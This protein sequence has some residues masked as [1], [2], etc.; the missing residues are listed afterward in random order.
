MT[1]S[2]KIGTPSLAWLTDFEEL[3]GSPAELVLQVQPNDPAF[4][5]FDFGP[6]L[7]NPR[8]LHLAVPPKRE[9]DWKAELGKI[10][11]DGRKTCIAN[12]L[13]IPPRSLETDIDGD[14]AFDA[15]ALLVEILRALPEGSSVA[16]LVPPMVLSGF[17][18]AGPRA[19][20]ATSHRLEWIVYLGEEA[21]RL[22]GASLGF[23]PTLIVLR[24]G[25]GAGEGVEIVRLVRLVDG[26]RKTWRK[27]L[28]TAARRGGGEGEA[29][30]VLRDP[31][32]G[33]EPWTYERFSKGFESK[34]EDAG[35]LGRLR[36]LSDFVEDIRSGLHRATEAGRFRDVE[37]DGSVPG[38]WVACF[39]GRSVR[40]GGELGSPVCAV[41]SEG[42]PPEVLLRPGDV[43]ARAIV[44][45]RGGGAPI[46]AA[47]V[48]EGALPASFDRTCLRIRWK[49][50]LDPRTADLLTDYLNSTHAGAWLQ[51]HGVGHT[52][53]IAVLQRLQVP[54]PSEDVLDA[55]AVL[56]GAEKQYRT[57]AEDAATARQQLFAATSFEQTLPTLLS[58][59]RIEI[60]RLRAGRDSESLDYRI[61]NY[62][63]HPLAIRREALLQLEHGKERLEAVLEC[64]EHLMAL[65]AVL[66][67][68]QLA[69]D[70]DV[71]RAIPGKQLPSFCSAGSLLLDWG[72]CTAAFE[73]GVSFTAKH[74]DPLSLPFP[75]LGELAG[76]IVDP[77]SG[78][79]RAT[80]K[81]RD[82]RNRQSH[83]QRV[84]EPELEQLSRECSREL[85]V[86]FQR[87]AFM[88]TTP[89]V[90]VADYVLEPV[91]RSRSATY[92]MLQGTSPVFQRRTQEVEAEVPRGAVGFL[93]AQSRFRS[94]IPWL[95]M[96]TCPVCKRSELFVFNRYQ[97]GVPVFV[98]MESGH[99]LEKSGLGGHFDS[100]I[101]R[102][103]VRDE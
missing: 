85:D 33:P 84:P 53:S 54:D 41:R 69:E 13:A 62:Y 57:W 24:V 55:L 51:A 52:L 38:G 82:R 25:R 3:L 17:R 71:A 35:R 91:S 27:T 43:L 78:W 102:A 89:L 48:P 81:L 9:G 46:L 80:E 45:V 67:M 16:A 64:G 21:A 98:A 31:E 5:K 32:L 92:R 100:L 99:T 6:D 79:K 56:T 20:L 28:H 101:K 96:E 40:Q 19:W 23:R 49:A 73:E 2:G 12:L 74:E 88:S 77:N 86:V 44:D 75:G 1:D 14:V 39:G 61:R 70:H 11:G 22:I 50:A 68:I 65:L 10:L 4:P 83:L 95:A 66:A 63:P 30:I 47:R 94:A 15:T 26:E 60:E 93:D 37:E 42:L 87:A 59:Q 58:R 29:F 76:E 36:P 34:L 97:A 72:K 18:F 90:Q 103:E 8:V 7:P